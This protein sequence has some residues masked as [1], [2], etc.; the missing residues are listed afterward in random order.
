VVEIRSKATG[1]SAQT[2]ELEKLIA[3]AQIRSRRIRMITLILLL[4]LIFFGAF[5]AVRQHK[6]AEKRVKEQLRIAEEREKNEEARKSL[7]QQAE[8]ARKASAYV[9]SGA[10]K[11]SHRNWTGAM[12]DYDKALSYDPNSPAALSY[13][14]YL[15]L[16]MG[17]AQEGEKMLRRAVEVDPD[18]IWNRYNFALALWATGNHQEAISQVREVLRLDPSF[19]SILAGDPQFHSFRS[20]PA[21]RALM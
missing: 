16:R 6:E 9:A 21:F 1:T 17:R 3:S 5:G 7:T 10:F 14:G 2:E 20:D 15:K 18:Q 4:G 13:E 8:N 12:A 19:K 11:A